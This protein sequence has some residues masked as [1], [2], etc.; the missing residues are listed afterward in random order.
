[1][2]TFTSC[3][4]FGFVSKKE[5]VSTEIEGLENSTDALSKTH[6]LVAAGNHVLWEQI[7]PN[8]SL[9]NST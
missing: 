6:R 3:S 7:S 2:Q 4:I 9:S 5:L 1:M 8:T